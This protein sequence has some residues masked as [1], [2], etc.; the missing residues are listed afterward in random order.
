MYCT[1]GLAKRHT[2]DEATSNSGKI[3]PVALSVKLCLAEGISKLVSTKF[4][5]IEKL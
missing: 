5:K 1:Y 4:R 2:Q 3:K